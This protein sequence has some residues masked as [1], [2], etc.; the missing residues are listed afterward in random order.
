MLAAKNSRKR[1][2][3]AVA[4]GSDQGREASGG[5]ERCRPRRSWRDQLRNQPGKR[6]VVALE[7]CNHRLEHRFRMQAFERER[8]SGARRQ[9]G[10][11]RELR[12]AVALAKGMDRVQSGQ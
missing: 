12:A 10:Q 1:V 4:G 2:A 9:H 5:L 6:R 7:A 11:I 3:R 8:M